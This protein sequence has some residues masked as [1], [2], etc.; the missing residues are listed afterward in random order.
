MFFF[1]FFKLCD[2]CLLTINREDD[3]WEKAISVQR[4]EKHI[5]AHLERDVRKRERTNRS[6]LSSRYFQDLFR[7]LLSFRL[8]IVFGVRAMPQKDVGRACA[9]ITR[10]GT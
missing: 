5:E 6:L 3:S 7:A 10:S 4:E 1:V 8:F 9:S 2:I